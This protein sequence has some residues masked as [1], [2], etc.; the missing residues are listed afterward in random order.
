MEIALRKAE[1]THLQPLAQKIRLMKIKGK[2]LGENKIPAV[3][4]IYFSVQPPWVNENADYKPSPLFTSRQWSVGR[5]IDL[6]S[7]KLKVVNKNNEMN[8]PKLR[9][10]RML[11]GKLLAKTTEV[12]MGTLMGAVVQDGDS[13]IMDYV[14][15]ENLNE[16]TCIDAKILE[17][18]KL[19]AVQ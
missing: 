2:A 11:D 19:A 17:K 5:T 9:L 14:K 13:L 16:E 18:Y 7:K 6:F 8:E 15:E 10:F 4:R 1:T 3:D 12:V